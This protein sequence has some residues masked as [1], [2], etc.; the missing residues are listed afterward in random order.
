[1]V[2]ESFWCYEKLV[3][4]ERENIM[5]TWNKRS[6][7]SAKFRLEDKKLLEPPLSCLNA[8]YKVN[9]HKHTLSDPAV[10]VLGCKSNTFVSLP[11]QHFEGFMYIFLCFAFSENFEQFSWSYLN[12]MLK[13][14][15]RKC[16][17]TIFVTNEFF[18]KILDFEHKG[19]PLQKNFLLSKKILIFV[20]FWKRPLQLISTKKYVCRGQN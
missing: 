5:D 14:S 20:L 18:L 16:V 3:S 1:M 15:L 2:L 12:S 6:N 7:F 10:L 19:G 4:K 17:I 11:Q 13:N 9:F 8:R